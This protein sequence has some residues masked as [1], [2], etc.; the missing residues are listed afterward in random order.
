[1]SDTLI[2]DVIGVIK[3]L[4]QSFTRLVGIGSTSEDLYGSRR[5]RW[6]SSSTVTTL[7]L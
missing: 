2:E 1:M 6:R 5:S 3:M 7:I 4:M